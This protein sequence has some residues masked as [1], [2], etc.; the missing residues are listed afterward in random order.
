ML[1]TSIEEM[2]NPFLMKVHICFISD[3]GEILEDI[4]VRTIRNIE[5]IGEKL[6]SEYVEQRLVKSTTAISSLS[7]QHIPLFR[8]RGTKVRSRTKLEVADRKVNRDLINVTCVYIL[9]IEGDK[10][11]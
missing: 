10:S 11:G 8:K 7:K 6:H 3:P 2:G 1:V 4:V 5:T 9:P